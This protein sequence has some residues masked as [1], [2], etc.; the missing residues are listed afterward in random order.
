[1]R[2]TQLGNQSSSRYKGYTKAGKKRSICSR[3]LR[4]STARY[5]IVVGIGYISHR[6]LAIGIIPH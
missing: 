3:G 1:M 6:I 4:G 5:A 2:L